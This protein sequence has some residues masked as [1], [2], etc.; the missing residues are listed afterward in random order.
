MKPDRNT[1]EVRVETFK[2]FQDV[3]DNKFTPRDT[4][5]KCKAR[6]F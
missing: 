1:R 3:G 4:G 6:V 2:K 5:F